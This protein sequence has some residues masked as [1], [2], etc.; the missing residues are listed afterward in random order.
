M[1]SASAPAIECQ[2]GVPPL[3]TQLP[4]IRDQ[5]NTETSKT[6]DETL[7]TC[8]PFLKGVGNSQNGIFNELGVP[9]LNKG[10]HL[11]FIYDALEDYP[12]RFVGL[13]AS[14]PWMI[15]WAITALYLLGEDVTLLRK[16]YVF[17]DFFYIYMM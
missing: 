10:A 6:Q 1:A 17:V 7:E 16:R 12:G 4:K 8:L 2:P 15:Y 5:L 13:D 14:K 3:F 9:R 11:A